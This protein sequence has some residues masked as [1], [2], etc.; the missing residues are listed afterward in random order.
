MPDGRKNNGGK[1]PGQ[2]R[3]ARAIELDLINTILTGLKPY[4]GVKGLWEVVIKQAVEDKSVPHQKF[5][6]D[7]LYGKPKETVDVNQHT[8]QVVKVLY[9]K[10]NG[11][12]TDS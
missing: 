6:F 9:Q 3:P 12:R 11:K 5:V 10:I 7:Y 2:G 4:G 8:E 1:R